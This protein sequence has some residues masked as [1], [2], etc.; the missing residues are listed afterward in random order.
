MP[1]VE[2]EQDLTLIWSLVGH[3]TKATALSL[4]VTHDT[5]AADGQDGYSETRTTAMKLT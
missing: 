5:G 3:E 1:K 2:C 4:F